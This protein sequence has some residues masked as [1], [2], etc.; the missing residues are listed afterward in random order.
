MNTSTFSFPTTHFWRASFSLLLTW[1]LGATIARADELPSTVVATIDRVPVGVERLVA[2]LKETGVSLASLEPED[3][4][5]LKREMLNEVIEQEI[6]LR[7]ARDRGIRVTD[8]EVARAVAQARTDAGPTE[9]SA[10]LEERGLTAA[11]WERRLRDNLIVSRLLATMTPA[12]PAPT[13]V[14]LRAYYESHPEEFLEP[15]SVDARQI[16]VP[17]KSEAEVI[18]ARLLAGASF[19]EMAVARSVSPEAAD[20]GRLGDVQRGH[21]PEAFDVLFSLKLGE[22]SAVVHTP[23]GYHLFTV[24]AHRPATRL[25]YVDVADTLGKRLRQ[26]RREEAVAAWI[27]ERTSKTVIVINEPVFSAMD[28]QPHP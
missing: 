1:M 22:I 2:A 11:A 8:A 3:R 13:E 19:A 6:L 16:V 20:G 24:E 21:V 5:R 4:D 23:F 26:T 15:E 9:L 17:D 28:D 14:E 27:R 12:V 18:R 10:V 25:T 7:E